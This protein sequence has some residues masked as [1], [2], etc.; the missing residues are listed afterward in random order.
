MEFN[1]EQIENADFNND[2]I[3]NVLDVVSIVNLILFGNTAEPM[4]LFSLEDINPASDYYEQYIGPE[5]FTGDVS[6]YYFGK[7]G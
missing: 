6:L 3:V 1:D 2:D 4:P 7:A 5:T